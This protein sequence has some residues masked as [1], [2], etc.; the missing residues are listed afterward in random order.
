MPA[1]K[2]ILQKNQ[3][4]SGNTQ[5]PSNT[6]QTPASSPALTDADYFLAVAKVTIKTGKDNKEVNSKLLVRVYPAS[7]TDNYQKGYLL[8]NY[9][10]ELAAG[11]G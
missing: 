6:P 11:A 10:P 1:V 2:P 3:G 7:G 4:N 8:E 5:Q 9:M